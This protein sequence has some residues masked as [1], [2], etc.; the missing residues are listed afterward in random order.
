MRPAKSEVVNVEL[1]DEI[2]VHEH[3][4]GGLQMIIRIFQQHPILR[5]A[6]LVKLTHMHVASS[7]CLPEYL[8]CFSLLLFVRMR[9]SVTCVFCNVSTLTSRMLDMVAHFSSQS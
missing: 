9:V 2:Q 1:V 8:V 4:E 3:A 7:I 6:A 5:S